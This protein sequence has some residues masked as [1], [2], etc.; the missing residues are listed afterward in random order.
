MSPDEIVDKAF[1]DPAWAPEALAELARLEQTAKG[2][3]LIAVHDAAHMVSK[4][5]PT[6]HQGGAS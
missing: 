5:L 2:P 3:D 4:L 6:R 1:A